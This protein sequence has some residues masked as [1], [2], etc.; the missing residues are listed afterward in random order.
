MKVVE[1]TKRFRNGEIKHTMLVD[2]DS[3]D[4]IDDAARYWVEQD[5]SGQFYGY[6][7]EWIIITDPELIKKAYEKEI[8]NINGKIGYYA[9][10]KEKV[11]TLLK[12]MK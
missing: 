9:N 5:Q 10:Q 2:T 4:S 3:N 7:W 11:E 12:E 8:E 1:I 6:S